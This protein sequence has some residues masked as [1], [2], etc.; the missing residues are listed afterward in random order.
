MP[1][2]FRDNE[3]YWWYVLMLLYHKTKYV[4]IVKID[5]IVP[6]RNNDFAY[7]W[8]SWII[9]SF[10]WFSYMYDEAGVRGI[11]KHIVGGEIGSLGYAPPL[12]ICPPPLLYTLFRCLVAEFCSYLVL[13]GMLWRCWGWILGNGKIIIRLL[14]ARSPPEPCRAPGTQQLHFCSCGNWIL[15]SRLVRECYREQKFLY[16]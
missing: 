2:M 15:T 7:L 13:L 10:S 14:H 9:F 8:K 12:P 1:C 16:T 5:S 4:E 11:H 6:K 3:M